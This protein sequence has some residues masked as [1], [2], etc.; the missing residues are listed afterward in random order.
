MTQPTRGSVIPRPALGVLYL[1]TKFGDF[2][3][4]R[5]GDI[6]AGVKI[7]NGLFDPDH[8]PFGGGLLSVS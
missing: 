8:E 6:I 7:K 5:S 4:S 2:R 3:F 1:H